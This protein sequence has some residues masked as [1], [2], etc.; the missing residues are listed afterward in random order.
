[1]AA[2][3]QAIK[4]LMLPWL[5]H[6]HITPFFELAK[7]LAKHRTIFQIYVCSTHVNLQAIDPNLARTHSIELVEL[8]LPSLPD[9]PPHMHTTKGIPLHLEPTLMKAFD[10]AAKDFELLLDRLEPDLLV[11]DLFQPWAVQAAAARNVPV[12]NFVVTGVA[13]LTRL[14]HAFCNSGREFPFPEID[15]SGHWSSKRGRKVSDEV[16]RDWALRVF[17]CL[18]MS[19]DVVLVNTSPEFEGK[20]IDFLASSFNKK[21]LPIAP[22]VPQIKPN[23]EKPEILKWLD[24]KSPKSTVYVS[25]GSEYYLT[26][27]DREELAHGLEQSHVNFI[28]V[29][30]FPKGESLTIEEALPEGYMKRVGDRGLIMEGWAP[31]LEILNHSSVGAFVCHCGWNSV[32][33]SVMF[34][35]PIVALP[36]QLDQPWHA[37]VANLAGV[38]VEAERDDEGNVK[39][40]GVA[41]AIKEV[42]FEEIGEALRGKAREIGEALR[43]R[44]GGIVDV[45]VREFYSLSEP[46]KERWVEIQE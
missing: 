44:E 24:K 46:I 39:R 15:F 18:R 40:E 33:E 20:Y 10:M 25:F 8:H 3:K 13:V 11:S 45:V 1:M 30:R 36:M 22:M 35:V 38:C 27:Q 6:G 37:K 41:K 43:K 28:W 5:A 31:Q 21:I 7:R 2:Q 32:V 42:V 29:I 17:K 34:G 26:N 16:G 12:V 9:L 4:I 23:G 14:V 19:S